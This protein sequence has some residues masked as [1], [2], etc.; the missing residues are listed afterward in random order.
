[1]MEWS[2]LHDA[3]GSDRTGPA[4]AKRFSCLDEVGG[5]GS[6]QDARQLA[7]SLDNSTVYASPGRMVAERTEELLLA[8]NRLELLV[9]QRR[10]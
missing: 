10:A 2:G 9:R 3:G 8:K 7:V 5:L 6:G 4:G 1:M